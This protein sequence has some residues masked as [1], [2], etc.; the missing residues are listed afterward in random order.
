MAKKITVSVSDVLHQKIEKWRNSFNLSKMFQDTL[1]EAI[2]KKEDFIKRMRRDV[3]M[4]QTIERLKKE[5]AETEKR[6]HEHGRMDGLRWAQ[7]AHYDDLEQVVNLK[8]EET[9]TNKSLLKSYFVEIFKNRDWAEFLREG[10][11]QKRNNYIEGW[12]RGV[13]EFWEEVRDKI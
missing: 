1:S 13:V 6:Y 12:K 5:K 7:S 8:P 9:L 11:G 2:K 10:P 3:D 4:E